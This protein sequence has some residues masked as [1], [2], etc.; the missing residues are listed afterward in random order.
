[1]SGDVGVVALVPMRSQSER[2]PGKN[3]RSCAGRPLYHWVIS[4]LLGC[5]GVSGVVIDTDSEEII[6]DAARSFPQVRVLRRPARLGRGEVSMNEVL[7]NTVEQLAGD[8]FL[9]THST[10]P[11]LTVPT[12]ER[13]LGAFEAGRSTH[14]TLMSVTAWQKRLW[15]TDGEPLNH[16]PGLL[17]RTQDLPPVYEENSAF[18]IFSRETL[19]VARNRIGARPAFF[20][21]DQLEAWDIDDEADFLVAEV[22]IKQTRQSAQ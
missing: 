3:L 20:E 13:A 10:S 19:M 16:D 11:L 17:L 18:Y 6:A 14:D 2:V 21:V 7:L 8:I 1:M 12:I 22:L 9:Q 5:P 15:T 4:T